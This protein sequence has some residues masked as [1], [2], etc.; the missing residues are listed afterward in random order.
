MPRR[1]VS[2]LWDTLTKVPRIWRRFPASPALGTRGDGFR[3]DALGPA[4]RAPSPLSTF[5]HG[6]PANAEHFVAL[7]LPRVVVFRGTDE[8]A[9][10]HRFLFLRALETSESQGGA[11]VSHFAEG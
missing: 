8:E 7:S 6:A 2:H 1:G 4:L 3:R 10:G 5:G 9:A 11:A